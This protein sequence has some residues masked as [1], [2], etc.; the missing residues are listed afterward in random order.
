[1]IGYVPQKGML[2][3]AATIA[4]N[5]RYGRAER[6]PSGRWRNRTGGGT[7]IRICRVELEE[8]YR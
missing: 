7:G 5:L 6:Q 4:S 3:S 1:M 8:G 2:F